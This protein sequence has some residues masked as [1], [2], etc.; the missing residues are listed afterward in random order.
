MESHSCRQPQY[1]LNLAGKNRSQGAPRA[2]NRMEVSPQS[3]GR[4]S[5]VR[6][7]GRPVGPHLLL[8]QAGS[9]HLHQVCNG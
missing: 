4:E 2:L 5:L 9:Q 8:Q 3:F 7:H 6:E 1:A